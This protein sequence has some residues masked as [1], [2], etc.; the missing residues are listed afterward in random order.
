MIQF[1]Q[2]QIHAQKEYFKNAIYQLLCFKEENNKSTDG[3]FVSL[4]QQLNGFGSICGNPNI[5]ITITSLLEVARK[6]ENHSTY[7]KALL[8]AIGFID[9][10]KEDV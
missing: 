2:Q 4:Q 8:D 3:R 5:I 9:N 7:R 1:T 10:V 6:E